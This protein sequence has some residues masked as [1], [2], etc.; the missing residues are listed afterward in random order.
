MFS[1]AVYR[2]VLS[3]SAVCKVWVKNT[4]EGSSRSLILTYS[5]VQSPS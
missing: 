1:A 4:V 3:G 2:T 5:M